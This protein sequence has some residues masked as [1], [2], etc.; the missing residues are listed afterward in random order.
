MVSQ[1]NNKVSHCVILVIIC[2]IFN[3]SL[4]GNKVSE[5]FTASNQYKVEINQ[6]NEINLLEKIYIDES[7]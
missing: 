7:I 3:P 6:K 2:F 4:F 1:L 5:K